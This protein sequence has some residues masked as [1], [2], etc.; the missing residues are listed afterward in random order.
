MENE[1]KKC[2]TC[3]SWDFKVDGGNGAFGNCYNKEVQKNVRI[4]ARRCQFAKVVKSKED[5]YAIWEELDNYAEIQFEENNF[6]CIHWSK[7]NTPGAK[8]AE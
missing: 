1:E 7:N 4:S 2:G 3:K 6:G 5:L 8:N